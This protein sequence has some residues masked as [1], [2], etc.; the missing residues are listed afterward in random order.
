[1]QKEIVTKIQEDDH[2]EYS[3]IEQYYGVA[4]IMQ[5]AFLKSYEPV[6]K[7]EFPKFKVNEAFARKWKCDFIELQGPGKCSATD[8]PNFS[9]S[10][11][12]NKFYH[13]EL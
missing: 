10:M 9:I 13:D 11:K 2:L 1:M 7:V 4:E 6:V 5:K 3:E 8:Y 12:D